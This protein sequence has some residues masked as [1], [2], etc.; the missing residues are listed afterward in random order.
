[1]L[2]KLAVA[3]R[4]DVCICVEQRQLAVD[5]LTTVLDRFA[6]RAPRAGLLDDGMFL[7]AQLLQ[8]V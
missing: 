2:A 7:A 1:M 5:L 6:L 3:E 4:A 8:R